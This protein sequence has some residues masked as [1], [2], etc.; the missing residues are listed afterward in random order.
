MVQNPNIEKHEG[1]K[2]PRLLTVLEVTNILGLGQST[3]YLLIK[4]GELTCVRIGRAVRVRQDDLDAFI[5]SKV[6]KGSG[7]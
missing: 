4:R 1:E 3:T 6:V 7:Y 5:E 2:L